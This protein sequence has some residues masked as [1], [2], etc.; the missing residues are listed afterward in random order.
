MKSIIGSILFLS[1][2]ATRASDP[3]AVLDQQNVFSGT[4]GYAVA[5]RQS[6]AQT[7]TCGIRGTLS[8]VDVKVNRGAAA[9]AD[10]TMS[11]WSTYNGR[12][13]LMLATQT[14]PA[15]SLPVSWSLA[16]FDGFALPVTPGELIGIRLDSS[17]ANTSPWDARYLWANQNPGQYSGGQV[18]TYPYP[19]TVSEPSVDLY[20]QTYIV[21]IPEPAVNLLAIAG[22]MLLWVRPR[23]RGIEPRFVLEHSS[24]VK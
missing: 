2:I 10:L 22:F 17:A 18:F 7:V 14:L 16:S 8:R 13:V 3:S 6:A 12:P 5:N 15:S 19:A 20:F 11:L 9:T 24:A 4:S 1:T 21:A 23:R